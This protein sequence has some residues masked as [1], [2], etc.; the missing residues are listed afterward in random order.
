MQFHDRTHAGQILAERLTRYRDRADVLV[1]GLPRGGM[2]VAFEVA[3]TLNAPLDVFLVRK[4]GTP[5]HEELAM[6]AIATGGVR[7]LNP[8]IVQSL[9]IPA[10][11]I[12]HEVEHEQ[13]ELERRQCHYRGDRPAPM[14]EGRIVILVDDGLA[15]GATMRAAAAA[16]R[17]LGPSRL[18]IAVPV[19]GADACEA[20]RE[21]ADEVVCATTPG[22]LHAVSRAYESFDQTTD[23]EVRELL[24]RADLS[25]SIRTEARA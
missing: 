19:G 7:V 17:R 11:D 24:A 4:L 12:A 22:F 20:M 13:R 8:E 16:V 23:E 9:D 18:V 6:G 15:T 5:G 3:R 2:P 21:E 10:A 14:I 25:L 1:L